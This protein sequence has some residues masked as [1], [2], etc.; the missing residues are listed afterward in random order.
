[1]LFIIIMEQN[2][3]EA[4]VL[5]A[6]FVILSF[7][8]NKANFCYF[9]KI[10]IF[11]I[12]LYLVMLFRR[13]DEHFQMCYPNSVKAPALI[14]YLSKSKA[15]CMDESARGMFDDP[16]NDLGGESVGSG[17]CPMPMDTRISAEKSEQTKL[18][19]MCKLPPDY[20]RY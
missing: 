4:I 18:K 7:G 8:E 16:T 9:I 5:I 2:L 17:S 11:S 14:S 12:I 19:G 15:T 3:I 6:S 10:A 13:T 20:E 1:M